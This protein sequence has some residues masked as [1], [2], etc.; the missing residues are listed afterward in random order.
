MKNIV[1][2]LFAVLSLVQLKAQDLFASLND[3]ATISKF[4]AP[5]SAAP[6]M[7]KK[8]NQIHT[9]WFNLNIGAAFLLDHNILVRTMRIFSK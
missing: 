5:M 7:A 2:S 4:E 9:K 1:L 3:T 6:V 8:W